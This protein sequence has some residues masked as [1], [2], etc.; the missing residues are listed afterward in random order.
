MVGVSKEKERR[1]LDKKY[2]L[3]KIRLY[4]IMAMKMQSRR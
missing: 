4:N 1:T 3:D 2:K